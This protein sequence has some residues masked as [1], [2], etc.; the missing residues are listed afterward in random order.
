MRLDIHHH[1]SGFERVE[2]LLTDTNRLLRRLIE[3]GSIMTI[4]MQNLLREVQ[5]TKGVIASAKV[6]IASVAE[7]LREAAEDKEAVIAIAQ[8]LSDAT[9]DLASAIPAN[10]PGTPPPTE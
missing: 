4:E 8:E 9:D 3:Q 5:E 2:A 10:D 1:Y 7:R 6:F